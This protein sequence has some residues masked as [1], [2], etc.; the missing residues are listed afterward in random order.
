MA[1]SMHPAAVDHVPGFITEPGQADYLFN[2]V[3]IFLIVAVLVI[4]NLY[5]RLHAVPER[6][7]HRTNKVQMEVVAVL[8]LISL[9]THNHLYW[10]A[11]LL[12][13]FV[14]IPDFTT[15]LYSI[16]QSLAKLAGRDRVTS[17]DPALITEE[18]VEPAEVKS[19]TGVHGEGV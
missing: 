15:P 3:A 5:F 12:L 9:F 18:P 19:K 17:G 2:G 7:A 10:I 11:G 1:Q 6:I 4:G 13:A 14:R 8:V 16:A